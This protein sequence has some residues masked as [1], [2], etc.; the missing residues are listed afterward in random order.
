MVIL[1][2]RLSFQFD[3]YVGIHEPVEGTH[4]LNGLT[5]V[6]IF[7]IVNIAKLLGIPTGVGI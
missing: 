6:M 5:Q 1:V 4:A 3:G 7:I 2:N